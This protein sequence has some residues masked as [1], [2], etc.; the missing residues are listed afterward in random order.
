[1]DTYG[2]FR[3]VILGLPKGLSKDYLETLKGLFRLWNI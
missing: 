3:E 2:I 1:M